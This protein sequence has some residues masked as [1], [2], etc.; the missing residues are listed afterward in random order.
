MAKKEGVP[1]ALS[2]LIARSY[3]HSKRRARKSGRFLNLFK[4]VTMGPETWTEGRAIVNLKYA[5]LTIEAALPQ[6]SVDTSVTGSWN[7]E[8]SA[9]WRRMV[10][11]CPGLSSLMGCVILLEDA[12]DKAWFRPQVKHLLDCLPKYWKAINDASVPSIATRIWLLDRAIIY[13]AS[14]SRASSSGGNSGK[15]RKSR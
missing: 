12:I 15:S 3:L 14:G 4:A 7:P 8:S 10:E 1:E 5:L 11:N 2:Y 9:Y 13:V 6:G